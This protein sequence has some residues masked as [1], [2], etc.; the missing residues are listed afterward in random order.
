MIKLKNLNPLKGLRQLSS[1]YVYLPRKFIL[2]AVR[3]KRLTLSELGG[4]LIFVLSADWDVSQYRLGYIRF[5]QLELADIWILSS[6]TLSRLKDRF[7]KRGFLRESLGTVQI[8]NYQ[9]LFTYSGVKGIT[10]TGVSNKEIEAIFLN[11]QEQ[12][13]ESQPKIANKQSP[14]AKNQ[15]L[16]KSSFKN[17]FNGLGNV[18]L[19][20]KRHTGIRNY[21]KPDQ[22]VERQDSLTP[23]DMEWANENVKEENREAK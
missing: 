10:K 12:N 1:G 21:I 22:E 13:L 23:E 20:S 14:K 9:E 4:Y 11:P 17:E 8:E 7:V 3:G 5:T 15:S 6:S 2:E 16:F 19:P 18:R